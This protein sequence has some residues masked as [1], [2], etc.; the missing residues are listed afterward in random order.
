MFR[1]GKKILVTAIAI[2]LIVT[3]A[4]VNAS[5][6]I[7]AKEFTT[8]EQVLQAFKSA[9]E[10]GAIKKP[11]ISSIVNNSTENALLEYEKL[12]MNEVADKINETAPSLD[13]NQAYREMSYSLDN[14]ATV[15][16]KMYDL[17]E[18]EVVNDLDKSETVD[19][20]LSTSA[21]MPVVTTDHIVYRTKEKAYGDRYFTSEYTYGFPTGTGKVTLRTE[22]HYTISSSGLEARYGSN[23]K[24]YVGNVTNISSSW[25]ITDRY[26][27]TPGSTDINVLGTLKYDR[28]TPLGLIR[29][30][31][32]LKLDTRVGFV[33]INK[34]KKVATVKE[35]VYIL[36]TDED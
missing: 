1:N 27:E 4:T 32:Y 19:N 10:D 17:A 20:T 13:T 7:D 21:I 25:S 36:R 28:N 5:T 18:G 11:E 22:N 3:S 14:G 6:S 15:D 24:D 2:G 23:S 8:G 16:L 35:H 29:G 12:A 31:Y 30:P 9:N 34:T 26:A 33:S